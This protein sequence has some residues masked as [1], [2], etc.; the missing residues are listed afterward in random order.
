MARRTPFLWTLAVLLIVGCGEAPPPR[1]YGL[2]KLS[3]PAPRAFKYLGAL[4]NRK[5]EPYAPITRASSVC[6][7]PDGSFFYSDLGSGRIHRF[8][9]EGQYRGT[10]D[11]P[12]GGFAP[13]DMVSLGFLVYV[14]DR[15][16]ERIYRFNQDGALRDTVLD[17]GLLETDR[18]VRISAIDFDRDG[19]IA[20][21]DEAGHRVVVTG[22]F[23]DL[24]Y[25]VGEYGSFLGQMNRPWGVCFGSQG[26]LYVSDRGNSRVE[27]FDGT[28]QVL[29]ATEGIGSPHPLMTAPSGMDCDRFGN[30]YVC[31]PGRGVVQVLAPDLLPL[32]TVGGDEFAEDH[33]L[34][35]SDCCVGPDDRLYVVDEGRNALLV[36]QIVFP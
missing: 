12:G 22:P 34:N 17:L 24:E 2:E 27:V 33:M 3:A 32:A 14:L 18:P 36:Y 6:V 7:L 8:D 9:S 13:M 1:N 28:G 21:A 4:E 30:V 5:S 31:D 10:T 20:L 26:F 19:R 29:A 35:P 23:L 15:G 16:Q 11:D 25:S